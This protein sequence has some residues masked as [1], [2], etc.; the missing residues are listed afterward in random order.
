MK[1]A[2]SIIKSVTLLSAVALLAWSA[3]PES[4]SANIATCEGAG[5]TCH[6]EIMGVTYH[7]KEVE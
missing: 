3:A 5:H 2:L 6:V 4:S 1:K 7:Y